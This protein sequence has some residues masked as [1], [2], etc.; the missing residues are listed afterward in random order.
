MRGR[1]VELVEPGWG[2]EQHTVAFISKTQSSSRSSPI[3]NECV[4]VVDACTEDSRSN[5][6]GIRHNMAKHRTTHAFSLLA[7]RP[8]Q[9][10]QLHSA[11]VGGVGV[12]D[13][14]GL[15]GCG[16][17]VLVGAII[18]VGEQDICPERRPLLG[19]ER[20]Q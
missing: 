10:T 13:H 12:A 6:D 16:R 20:L 7:S 18:Q 17:H 15:H 5:P 2:V 14:L 9:A 19:A 11:R 3:G 8:N 4:R 1:T